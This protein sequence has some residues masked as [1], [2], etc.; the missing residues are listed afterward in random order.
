MIVTLT[1]DPALDVTY[2][3]ES[4]VLGEVHQ[5]AHVARRAGG[6]AA[7]V[8]GVLA[9][10]GY[11]CA[12]LAPLGGRDLEDIE[13]D[14]HGWGV[15]PWTIPSPVATRRQLVIAT[16]GQTTILREPGQAQPHSV[17]DAL[18]RE[19]GRRLRPADV[20]AIS[21][22]VPDGAPI[23]LIARLC[24]RA[25]TVGA[26]VVLDSQGIAAEHTLA[27]RPTVITI[28]AAAATSLTGVSAPL[29]AASALVDRGARSAVISCDDGSLVAAAPGVAARA[30][31]HRPAARPSTW[32]VDALTAAIS[33]R[34]HCLEPGAPLPVD[35][36]W[37]SLTLR[38]GLLWLSA[39]ALQPG[40]G[41]IDRRDVDALSPTAIVDHVV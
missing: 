7:N 21:G 12:T 39:A 30:N 33:A 34:L 29:A 23:D 26:R 19:V 16:R 13:A 27:L 9:S 15:D 2:T 37:W 17:W 22:V 41:I 8:A 24:R 31:L 40:A 38:M 35:R 32:A 28:S 5:V 6:Q 25:S 11:R 4:A 1:P 20:L 10:Q 3:L 14:L 18:E 36:P